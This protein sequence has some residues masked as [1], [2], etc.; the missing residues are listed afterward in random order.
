VTI[1]YAFMFRNNYLGVG[2]LLLKVFG[3]IGR[4]K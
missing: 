3:T 4:R 1:T 2:G